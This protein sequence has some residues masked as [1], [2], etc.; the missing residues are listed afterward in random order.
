MPQS[1]KIAYVEISDPYMAEAKEEARR[2]STDAS[3]STGAIIVKDGKVVAKGANQSALRDPRLV[4]LHKKYC[5]R[6]LFG[7]PSGKLYFLCPGCASHK[8]HG[9]F[10][11]VRD[12]EK[13]KADMR[14]ARLYLW[15]HWWCCKPCWDKM[16]KAGIS[17]AT[18]L[19]NSEKLFNIKD[20]QNIV[21][22]Q[23][24]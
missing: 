20:P 3:I 19:K 21:G 11:A 16:L 15:G 5:I 2:Y 13:H 10:R 9:E 8:N 14:G 23:F 4:A 6:R 18:L 7:V 17:D 22:H 24:D 12:G 1:G